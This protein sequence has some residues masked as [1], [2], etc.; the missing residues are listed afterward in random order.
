MKIVFAPDSYKESLTAYEVAQS[1]KQGFKKIFPD[2]AFIMCPMADGGEGTVQSLVD[3]TGG[4]IIQ[5]KVTGLLGD[6]VEALFGLSGDKK[7]AVIEMASSSGIHLVPQNL[8]DPKITTTKGVGELISAALDLGVKKFIIGIGGSA[9]ND[10]GAGMLQ[11]LGV[12]LKDKAGKEL[13][14]GGLAL[15]ELDSL[16]V[17][18]LDPRLSEVSIL[19]A[20]DVS[21]PLTGN[22]GASAIYGPQ[23]GATPEDV[24]KLD[25]ALIHFAA[26]MKQQLGKDVE[27]IPGAG[28][29]GGLGA[30]FLAFLP[31]T[32][33]QGGKIITDAVGLEKHVQGADFVI[34][35]EGGINSQTVF[36][37][38]PICVAEVAKKHG[39]P[40][41]AIC[42]SIGEGYEAVY[43]AGI[44]VVFSSLSEVLLM[45]ELPA[46]A[47]EHVRQIS[48]NVARLMKKMDVKYSLE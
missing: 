13:R 38:T 40:V 17:S 36:G 30:A 25:T 39:V 21:N 31:A 4:Q 14:P 28:V 44:D 5:K 11:E 8:K 41:I 27:H 33:E 45:E 24:E 15:K 2:A 23:K 35:G 20:C 1:M 46:K 42:G 47:K 18:N 3:A 26:V 9:T 22:S 29:A 32:L 34:T 43:E 37:K 48:E 10:G 12:R 16:D 7:T 19:V 6:T